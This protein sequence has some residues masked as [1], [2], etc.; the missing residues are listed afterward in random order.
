M[1]VRMAPEAVAGCVRTGVQLRGLAACCAVV[2]AA[3]CGRGAPDAAIAWSIE[4]PALIAGS[5]AT[6]ALTLTSGGGAP[7]TGA[8]LR[9][10]A[11]M[12]HPGMPPAVADFVEREGGRYE[13]RLQLGMAG[14][15]MLVASGTLADGTRI[16]RETRLSVR[17]ADGTPPDR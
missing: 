14:D 15:W 9:L 6:V 11:H 16:T 5:T 1:H 4:P 3:G 8:K 12:S 2:I 13:A 17:P 10:E 7:T